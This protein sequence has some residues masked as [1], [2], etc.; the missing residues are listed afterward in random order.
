MVL[1]HESIIDFWDSVSTTVL[2]HAVSDH[3]PILLQ[4]VKG[5]QLMARP[6][7]FQ[8]TWILDC[9]FK[10]L[11]RN[12]WGQFLGS[13]DPISLVIK[14]QKR[15]KEELRLWNKKQQFYAQKNR[16]SWLKDGDRNMTF[17]HRLHRIKNARPGIH[18]IYINGELSTDKDS[19]CA[20]IENFY[21]SLSSD[22]ND[23]LDFGLVRDLIL[24]SRLNNIV[25]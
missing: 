21:A 5:P 24:W 10:G 1:A 19:I 15:L 18:A 9:S 2:A 4:C 11:V 8:T 7:K 23:V 14:K 12:S 20:H 3:H 25:T 17:F 22:P 6:F 13:S 16:A